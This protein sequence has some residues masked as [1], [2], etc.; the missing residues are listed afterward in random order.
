MFYTVEFPHLEMCEN[1]SNAKKI[2]ELRYPQEIITS[3]VVTLFAV[4]GPN[5]NIAWMSEQ[6]QIVFINTFKKNICT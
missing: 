5:L 3:P 6:L 4:L 2:I 1:I